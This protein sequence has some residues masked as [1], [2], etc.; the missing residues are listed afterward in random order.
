MKY[1]GIASNILDA[2][3]PIVRSPTIIAMNIVHM[4]TNLEN[5][6]Q[7]IIDNQAS[8]TRSITDVQAGLRTGS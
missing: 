6:T 1:A 4:L 2:L 5:I 8:I 3:L 7:K